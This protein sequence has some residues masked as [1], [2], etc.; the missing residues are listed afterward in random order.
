MT[1]KSPPYPSSAFFFLHLHLNRYFLLIYRLMKA[2]PN[3]ILA[4]CWILA[5]TGC[6]PTI[7]NLTQERV[8]QNP[9]G[10]YTLSMRL[11]NIE[12]D[13]IR[14]TIEPKVVIGGQ[15]RPMRTSGVA[16]DVYEYDYEMPQGATEANFYYEVDYAIDTRG[17]TRPRNLVS[18]LFQ[19]RL[20]NR[21]II[22]LEA[23]RGPVGSEI[24]VVGRG[25][26]K[27]DEI[28]IGGIQAETRY[29]SSNSL[30]FKVP[31]LPAGKA[32]PVELVSGYGVI[33]VGFF[34][35]DPSK[36]RVSPQSLQLQSGER[37]VL[38]FA[39][40]FEAPENGFPIDVTT[41]VPECIIMPEVVIPKGARSVSIPV[42]G[43]L[44]GQGYLFANA[45]GFDELKIPVQVT[46]GAAPVIQD[47]L[48]E[49]RV[50][51]VTPAQ[52]GTETVET[53]EGQV[54]ILDIEY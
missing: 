48:I 1:I 34:Q 10:I 35:V 15:A 20:I 39:I 19:M 9:S 53:V 7:S 45:P 49:E 54:E 18:D 11:Q 44:G 17:G 36:L 13:A 41:N 40:D 12:P 6:G 5:L 37:G 32:Y 52:D 25:F 38:V 51:T 21:Y 27:H 28:V 4:L 23:T 42:E 30:T 47:T 46:G 26:S 14:D 43:G 3:L 22:T 33:P 50:F 31:A 2:K 16:A 24:S 8:P 29:D